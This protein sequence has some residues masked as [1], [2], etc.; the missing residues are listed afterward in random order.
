MG[1]E[2]PGN[3]VLAILLDMYIVIAGKSD[4]VKF[5]LFLLLL[6]L[7]STKKHKLLC[8]FVPEYNS[9]ILSTIAPKEF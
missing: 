8:V 2:R 7:C 9:K 4:F 3:G 6:L 5:I 1:N